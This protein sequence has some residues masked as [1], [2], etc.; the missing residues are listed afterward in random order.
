MT[1]FYIFTNVFNIWPR[2]QLHSLICFCMWPVTI[3]HL[4]EIDEENTVSQRYVAGKG[5]ILIAFSYHCGY[6]SP[7]QHQN[8]TSA[9]FLNVES[10]TI[11]IKLSYFLDWSPLT[12]LALWMCFTDAWLCNTMHC[13]LR[14]HVATEL[15]RSSK[16]WHI[17][18]Y[19]IKN[20]H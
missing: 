8:P 17:P 12:Y 3:I 16:C 18:L 2:R 13:S 1:L 5:S 11:S 14:K 4:V 19:N 6:S 7:T 15:S 20:S 10:E 9:S